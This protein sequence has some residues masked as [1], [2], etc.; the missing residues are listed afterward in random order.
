MSPGNDTPFA[1]LIHGICRREQEYLSL[2]FLEIPRSSASTQPLQ[3]PQHMAQ[4]IVAGLCAQRWECLPS[5]WMSAAAVLMVNLAPRVPLPSWCTWSKRPSVQI[6]GH[7]QQPNP[8]SALLSRACL[9]PL[10][11]D[12]PRLPHLDL[13]RASLLGQYCLF[14]WA[15]S[16]QVVY[17]YICPSPVWTP[18]DSMQEPP[19]RQDITGEPFRYNRQLF[20][21]S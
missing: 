18:Y 4:E 5:R 11:A 19:Q 6:Q 7:G 12:A 3:G 2:H 8:P 13:V 17:G 14:I 16:A 20:I 9:Q 1:W 10:K 21:T 15:D